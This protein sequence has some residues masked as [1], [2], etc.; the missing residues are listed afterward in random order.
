MPK[1]EFTNGAHLPKE[2]LTIRGTQYTKRRPYQKGDGN[3]RKGERKA[4]EELTKRGTYAKRR[5]HQ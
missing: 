4:K 2:E 5:I 1:G 3:L